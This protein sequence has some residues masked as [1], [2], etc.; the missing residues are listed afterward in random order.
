MNAYRKHTSDCLMVHVPS[1]I[2]EDET[3]H[4][5]RNPLSPLLHIADLSTEKCFATSMNL[6]ITLH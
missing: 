1:Y 2:S 5:Q 6:K 3:A 4:R